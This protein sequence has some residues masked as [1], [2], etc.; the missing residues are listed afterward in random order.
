MP[1]LAEGLLMFLLNLVH[2]TE[3]PFPL[4]RTLLLVLRGGAWLRLRWAAR[5]ACAS[6]A[7]AG[8]LRSPGAKP[9]AAPIGPGCWAI[10]SICM[11]RDYLPT[12]RNLI[13]T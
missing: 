2:V 6:S 11:A 9:V 1:H 4:P 3:L 5:L 8:V 10:R 12:C 7:P 13:V